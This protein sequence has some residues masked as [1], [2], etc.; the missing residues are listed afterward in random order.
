MWGPLSIK[1]GLF[2]KKIFTTIQYVQLLTHPATRL[3]ARGSFHPSHHTPTTPQRRLPPTAS[4]SA[5]PSAPFARQH[6]AGPLN[7]AKTRPNRGQEKTRR[8][9]SVERGGGQVSRLPPSCERCVRRRRAHILNAPS[10]ARWTCTSCISRWRRRRSRRYPSVRP[11]PE[12]PRIPDI[13]VP[14]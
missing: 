6:F 1:R 12:L 9:G 8:S 3:Q 13:F 10:P 14:T 5:F 4:A 7:A 11:P 2:K